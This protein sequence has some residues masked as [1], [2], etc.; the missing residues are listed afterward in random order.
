[1]LSPEDDEKSSPI[2]LAMLGR[3]LGTEDEEYLK[4]MIS[5]YW[6][7]MRDTPTDLANFMSARDAF[8]LRDAAHAAKG[9]S[10]SVGAVPVASLLEKLQFAA[11]DGDWGQIEG[12]MPQLETAFTELEEYIGTLRAA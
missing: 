5:I 9:A 2:D 12:L 11:R 3:L 6:D 8:N 4:E 10:A 7:T 1:M